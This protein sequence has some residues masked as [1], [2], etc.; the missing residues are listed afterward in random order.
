[1]FFKLMFFF[2]LSGMEVQVL[3]IPASQRAQV[4]TRKIFSKEIDERR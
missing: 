2:L 4:Q 3:F 1:M